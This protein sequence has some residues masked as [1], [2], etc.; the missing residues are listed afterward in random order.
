MRTAL[1]HF[2]TDET[3]ATT[4]DWV[5][6]TGGV[7][8]LTLAMLLTMNGSASSVAADLETVLESVDVVELETLGREA[9]ADAEVI[10]EEGIDS[11]AIA[12][13]GG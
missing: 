13:L 1:H 7:I 8:G 12:G 10:G 2:W 5:V 4:V 9:V 11:G 3:G 6:L